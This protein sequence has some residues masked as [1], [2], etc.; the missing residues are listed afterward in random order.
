MLGHLYFDKFQDGFLITNDAGCYH[1]LSKEEFTNLT[2]GSLATDS[3]LFEELQKEHFCFEGSSEAFYRDCAESIRDGNSYLFESTSLFIFAI[4]N[5]CN[6]HCIYCQANGEGSLCR[7]TEAVAKAALQRIAQ[8]PSN[9]ITIEFQGGEPLMNYP[10][11]QYIVQS[12]PEIIKE[13]AIQFTLVSN[14]SLLTTEMADFFQKNKVSVSTSLDGHEVLH[15][16]N[17][18]AADK[19]SSFRNM[20]RGKEILEKVGIKTGAIQTTTALSLKYPA[21]IVKTY[22]DL[23][24]SQ[25]FVRPLTRLGSA[26]KRWDVIGYSPDQFLSFYKQILD[27][28]INY[29]RKGKSLVE[30][31]AALFLAKILGGK[32]VNYM[33]LRSPCGAGVGQIAITSNGNVY[34]C[35][36]GR[37]I[38]EAGDQAFLLGN[39][40]KDSYDDWINS[41]CCKAI[42][43]ASLLESLPGC[44]DCVYKPYCGVCPVVNYA[45]NGNITHV[46]KDR[47]KIYK[48][49]L[50]ILFKYI[51][52]AD[53]FILQLFRAWGQNC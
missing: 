46:S 14:L 44:C 24:Y 11:I 12:A 20:L 23:G 4:T 22:A 1:F 31:H 16:A 19:T 17:R 33:E 30:Y 9:N 39:V 42:C 18:P 49:I 10:M 47:C 51:K 3:A 52:D 53:P 5:E 50:N 45:I 7:M 27:E 13:K 37:M 34:T 26:A 6:N 29:N 40:F 43:S 21:E 32:A 38:A 8:C 41:S 36:E 25:L 48:G 15:N 2:N 28:V 35:D